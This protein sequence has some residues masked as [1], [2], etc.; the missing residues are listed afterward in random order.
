V[1]IPNHMGGVDV[2]FQAGNNTVG[3]TH[4]AD[5]N[6]ISSNGIGTAGPGILISGQGN[7]TLIQN[8][9]IGPNN[10]GAGPPVDLVAPPPQTSN[11]G[12]GVSIQGGAFSNKLITNFIAFNND[13][14]G[15]SGITDNSTGNFNL[16]SQNQIFLNPQNATPADAQITD[17]AGQQGMLNS[18]VTTALTTLIRV[19]QATTV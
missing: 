5:G 16:F 10:L 13:G 7:N 6:I 15:V 12:G 18:Q 1:Q 4:A 9:L 8:N 19:T 3:G 14:S 11:K 17:S 2:T